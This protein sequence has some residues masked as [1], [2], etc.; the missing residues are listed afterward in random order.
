MANRLL[1]QAYA[2]FLLAQALHGVAGSAAERPVS[3]AQRRGPQP[4]RAPAS[5]TPEPLKT[6]RLF[7][8][9]VADVTPAEAVEWIIAWS[10]EVPARTV[11]TT[12]LDHVMKL[13]RDPLFQRG[14]READ[15]VTADG[16]PFLWLARREGE[17]LKGLVTGSDLILPLAAAAERARRSVFL[18]GSTMERLHRAAKLLKSRHPRLEIRGA[19]APP[20][21]FERDPDIHAEVL[22]LIRT[23]RPDII[24]VALGAPKQEIW[25]NGMANAVRHGVFVNIGGGLDFLSGDVRRAPGWMRRTGTEWVWRAA[26][27]PARLGPRYGRILASLPSLYAMHRRD[28]TEHEAAQR[29][30]AIAVVS[31]ARYRDSRSRTRELEQERAD[32]MV[33]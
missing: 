13:R 3:P 29:R 7:G 19:Y 5:A 27:E 10:R 21:G 12:N 6:R 32:G 9:D 28:R 15:M 22:R 14:Y 4:R 23:A 11:I 18:F 30:R 20:F 24:L 16:T 25:S 1:R 17:P 8:I 33:R 31:D 26:M 2:G